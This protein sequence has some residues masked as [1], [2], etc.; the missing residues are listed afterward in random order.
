RRDEAAKRLR[1]E[2]FPVSM[3]GGT[4]SETWSTLWE[5]ARR[6]SHE[7]A[8]PGQAFPVVADDAH[9]VLCQQNLD[10]ETR[11][12]LRRFETFVVSTAE[13]ELRQARDILTKRQGAL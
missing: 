5:A 13:Q 7:H 8:Y 2:T 1:A 3:L 6:F 10:P 4:G 12:R 11:E 9:C